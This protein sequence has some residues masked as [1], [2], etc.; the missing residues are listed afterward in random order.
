MNKRTQKLV[1]LLVCLALTLGAGLLVINLTKEKEE[2]TTPAATAESFEIFSV[3]PEKIVHIDWVFSDFIQE[4][5]TKKDGTWIYDADPEAFFYREEFTNWLGRTFSEPMMSDQRIDS[6]DMEAMGFT[7][8]D[9]LVHLTMEDGTETTLTF[10]AST[11]MQ[12]TCYFTPDGENIYVV[13]RMKQAVFGLKLE[14][15]QTTTTKKEE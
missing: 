3:D 2:P 6:T 13:A 5:F 1:I 11:P 9:V 14:N 8:P 15:Y 4:S 7:E 10:G 12:N